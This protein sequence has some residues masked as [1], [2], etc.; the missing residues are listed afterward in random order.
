MVAVNPQPR[1]STSAPPKKGAGRPANAFSMSGLDFQHWHSVRHWS[2]D[3][4]PLIEEGGALGMRSKDAAFWVEVRTAAP[5]WDYAYVHLLGREAGALDFAP[6]M[7]L[8]VPT[9][10]AKLLEVWSLIGLQWSTSKKL[11]TKTYPE[12]WR[13]AHPVAFPSGESLW[14]VTLEGGPEMRLMLNYK[15]AWATTL[16]R[17]D[18]SRSLI[19]L[20]GPDLNDL[21]PVIEGFAKEGVR[22]K[23]N[24]PLPYT[25]K[26]HEAFL[27]AGSRYFERKLLAV[28]KGY[29]HAFTPH[30]DFINVP[31]DTMKGWEP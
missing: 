3:P 13:F 25:K 26:L 24:V 22:V 30:A 1:L 2:L 19:S 18:H 17:S 15:P 29:T 21:V 16:R 6:P 27:Q 7:P 14:F 31:L 9:Q 11:G 8:H 20:L 28:E 4:F 23:P 10:M 12:D 5:F